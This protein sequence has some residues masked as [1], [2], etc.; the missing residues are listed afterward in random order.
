MEADPTVPVEGVAM[1]AIGVAV[2]RARENQRS[3]RLYTDPLALAFVDSARQGFT[4]QRWTNL[5]E[6]ADAF[7]E[8]RSVAV[9]LVDDRIQEA[10]HAGITQLVMLGAGLDTRAFRMG[11]P[12]EVTAF[13]IDLPELFAFKESVLRASSAVPTC[14]RAVIPTDLRG[15]WTTPLRASGFDEGRP[16][17]WVDEGALAYLPVDLRR[18]V[19]VALTEASA[20]G[21]RFGV[22]RYSAGT[23]RQPYVGLRSLVG[24]STSSVEASHETIADVRKW[25]D[26]LGWDTNFQHWNDAVASLNRGVTVTDPEVGHVAA[27]RRS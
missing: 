27:V 6:L 15:D 10:I 20:P 13:E 9:R 2:I 25:L 18:D 19:V 3:D 23:D 22:S 1:T 21:S 5:E 11:L 17:L 16:A 7:Y 4:T 14:R 26:D 12:S 24:S 8:G